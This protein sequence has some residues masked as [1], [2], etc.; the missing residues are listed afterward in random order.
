MSNSDSVVSGETSSG[1]NGSVPSSSG[2][3]FGQLEDAGDYVVDSVVYNIENVTHN[4]VLIS[5]AAGGVL[6]TAILGGFQTGSSAVWAEDIVGLGA[7]SGLAYTLASQTMKFMAGSQSGGFL[8][9]YDPNT[10]AIYNALSAG[11][12]G[13]ALALGLDASRLA[14]ADWKEY[15]MYFL[16][17][18]GAVALGSYLARWFVNRQKSG[19]NKQ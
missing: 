17:V 18:G 2:D 9:V 10:L 14:G 15:G 11:V 12:I 7:I 6:G 13:G 8:P 19:G 16:K 1:G 4:A 5:A 3:I